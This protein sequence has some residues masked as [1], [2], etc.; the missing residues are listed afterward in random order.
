MIQTVICVILGLVAGVILFAIL[1]GKLLD[2]GFEG[3]E[4]PNILKK[5]KEQD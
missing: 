5:W 2:S 3:R 1:L 4:D